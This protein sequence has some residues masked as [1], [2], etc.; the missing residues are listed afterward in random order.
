VLIV[1]EGT[2][3]S[4]WSPNLS[5]GVATV[6][7]FSFFIQGIESDKKLRKY[8]FEFPKLWVDCTFI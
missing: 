6:V 3:D 2:S 1:E 5:T 4:E 7:I 8:L